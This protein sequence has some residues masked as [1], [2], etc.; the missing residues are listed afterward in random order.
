MVEIKITNPS[1][2]SFWIEK[3]G[4]KAGVKWSIKSQK[5][6]DKFQSR[7]GKLSVGREVPI[8]QFAQVLIIESGEPIFRGY[9]ES[10]DIDESR[11]KELTLAGMEKLLTYRYMPDAFYPVGSIT[12][13]DLFSHAC[14]LNEQPGMLTIGNGMIPPGWGHVIEDADNNTIKL[15][16][17]GTDSRLAKK[18]LFFI[19]YEYLRELAPVFS[20]SELAY[21]DL[22]YYRNA[23]DLWVRID[24]N[25]S[26]SWADRGGLICDGAFD[27]T[28]R[29]GACPT[30]SLMGDLQTYAGEDAVADLM[31][32][33]LL[34]HGHHLHIRDTRS[35][36]YFD[37]DDEEG[38]A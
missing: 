18:D 34:A 37:I 12:L 15:P 6:V 30:T 5:I 2:Q 10:Y 28:I 3:E 29:L 35:L 4:K 1:R 11:G 9:V 19:G 8:K 23:V 38:E 17:M 22:T 20:Y 7:E 31:T 13:D 14:T 33:T 32:D 27:T 16:R 24:H 21:I 25:Y 26:R 36:T